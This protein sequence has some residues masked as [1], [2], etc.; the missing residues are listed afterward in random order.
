V[1]FRF[2]KKKITPT[3]RVLKDLGNTSN[4]SECPAGMKYVSSN[5]LIKNFMLTVGVARK[6]VRVLQFCVPMASR[7]VQ[8]YNI[9]VKVTRL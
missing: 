1:T 9:L 3:H 6:G 2:L 7:F 8:S 5:A 4:N